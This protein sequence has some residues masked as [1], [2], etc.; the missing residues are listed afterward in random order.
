VI[1]DMNSAERW[2]PEHAC[3]A[4]LY[5]DE[6]LAVFLKKPE[7]ALAAANEQPGYRV[8]PVGGWPGNPS[9]LDKHLHASGQVEF[10]GIGKLGRAVSLVPAKWGS[11]GGDNEFVELMMDLH[12]ELERQGR[13]V[14]FVL[15]SRCSDGPEFI[16]SW[17]RNA[18]QSY[19]IPRFGRQPLGDEGYS[20]AACAVAQHIGTQG[21]YTDVLAPWLPLLSNVVML[22]GQHGTTNMRVPM[23][24]G[25][26]ELTSPLDMSGAYSGPLVML[27]NAWEDGDYGEPAAA[28]FARG[29]KRVTWICHD[30]RNYLKAR[31]VLRGPS[32]V[33]GQYNWSRNFRDMMDNLHVHEY[34]YAAAELGGV[35]MPDAPPAAGSER[36]V[37][38]GLIVNETAKMT[39]Q[40]GAGVGR[41]QCVLE[42][43]VPV[44]KTVPVMIEETP[45]SDMQADAPAWSEFHDDEPRHEPL[46][47]Y[48]PETYMFGTWTPESQAEIA[49][50]LGEQF[51]SLFPV[52]GV[53]REHV[54]TLLGDT[55]YS[56]TFPGNGQPWV[57]A[58]LWEGWSCG[59][60]MFMHPMYDGQNNVFKHARLC[61]AD[62]RDVM[63]LEQW[64]RPPNPEAMLK[65]IDYLE[66]HG[67]IA[68]DIRRAQWNV[69]VACKKYAMHIRR[70]FELA[71]ERL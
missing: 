26:G 6:E 35:T 1:E 62:E 42:W 57:T 46:R 7:N 43:A 15:V 59:V 38:F 47:E 2:K 48:K 67:E 27:A 33:L 8:Q 23:A 24:N 49:T 66:Q 5:T 50:A 36:S 11:V 12:E 65:G 64:L 32:P 19:V 3:G 41:L 54:L 70:I 71:P 68:D 30:S 55:R 4:P 56:V 21:A 51:A 45:V 13:N 58:K 22:L 9:P 31:D 29:G 40:D 44:M 52:K 39:A 17:V 53:V 28:A 14:V 60:I 37:K 61:G 10:W 34:Q 63:L 69:F 18:W 20:P 25:N 16:P